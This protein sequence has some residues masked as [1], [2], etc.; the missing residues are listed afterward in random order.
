[1]KKIA[2]LALC[3][4]IALASCQEEKSLTIDIN[5]TEMMAPEG[6]TQMATVLYRNNNA[7]DTAASAEVI[8]GQAK[9]TVHFDEPTGFY[10][11]LDAERSATA[12]FGQYGH[13]TYHGVYNQNGSAKLEGTP[14]M[15]VLNSIRERDMD[16]QA[17]WSEELNDAYSQAQVLEDQATMDSLMSIYES[18]EKEVSDYR[19]EQAKTQGAVGAHVALTQI[20]N[21]D[22][23][24]VSAVYEQFDDADS[25]TV[26][27]ELRARVAALGK[28]AVGQPYVDFT[29]Q[30]TTG[31]DL[32]VSSID[33]DGYLLIDFWASWCGP[34][35]AENPNL[36]TLYNDFKDQG[37]EIVGVSYDTD[38]RK[39]KDAIVED[40][41]TWPQMS[42]LRGWDNES[43]TTYV[44]NFIP[45]NV[46]IDSEGLIAGRNLSTEAIRELL[47]E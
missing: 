18:W 41:L 24:L 7:W 40:G 23:D 46:L 22:Y 37:F 43:R 11:K 17:R 34:C 47:S 38:G 14:E 15:D 44:I 21:A 5:L 3:S 30:D 6:V 1:M 29:Q 42:V 32:S 2:F 19:E 4:T 33:Y 27:S 8:D 10:L 35:R 20:Y 25:S 28:V 45:Q 13:L 12:G 16:M 26:V 9:L 36:V 39:W 31:V